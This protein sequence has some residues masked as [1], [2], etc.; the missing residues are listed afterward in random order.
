MTFHF[1]ALEKEM[2]T[3]S[4]VLAW[5]IPGMGEPSGQPSRGLTESDTTEATWK[6]HLTWVSAS[7]L[8]YPSD[9]QAAAQLLPSKPPPLIALYFLTPG[10]HNPQVTGR[11]PHCGPLLLSPLPLHRSFLPPSPPGTFSGLS[12]QI[13]LYF[14]CPHSCSPFTVYLN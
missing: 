6:Q 3:Y 13:S 12:K 2:A 1:H 9:T 11:L 10:S 4:S 7:S 5:R 8:E 14:A